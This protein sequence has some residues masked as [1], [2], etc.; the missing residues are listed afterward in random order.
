MSILMKNLYCAS[1]HIKVHQFLK[2]RDYIET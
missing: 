2:N 1:K